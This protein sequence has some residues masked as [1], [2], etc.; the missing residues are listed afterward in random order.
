MKEYLKN[1]ILYYILIPVILLI[2]VLYASSV[3]LPGKDKVWE[4]KEKT[5]N[6]M[7][8]L[9]KQIWTLAPER[10]VQVNEKAGGF[11]YDNAISKTAQ[12]CRVSPSNITP[13]IRG[14]MFQGGQEIQDASISLKDVGIRQFAMF[15][16]ISL[17]LWPDL[18]C[19]RLKL[20][21]IKGP[22]D[23]WKADMNFRYFY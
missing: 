15:L 12:L 13:N 10:V 7:Q 9:L 11:D 18:Q 5:Y 22:K 14:K 1:P 23:K 17:H 21:R 4:R 19:E 3:A 6:D 2:W 8:P 20:T 16:S